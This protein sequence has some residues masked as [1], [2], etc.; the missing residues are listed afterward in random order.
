MKLKNIFKYLSLLIL[1]IIMFG[2]LAA[3]SDTEDMRPGQM[4]RYGIEALRN[5]DLYTAIDY[6]SAYLEEKPADAKIQYK[7]GELYFKSR[8]YPAAAKCYD[9]AFTK[10]RRKFPQ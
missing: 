7:L 9:K 5:G 2:N 6:L 8:N 1:S 4:K 3:Q 10:K